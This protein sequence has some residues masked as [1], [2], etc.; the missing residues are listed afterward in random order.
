MVK[1]VVLHVY[2]S[3][4]LSEICCF[5]GIKLSKYYKG[6]NIFTISERLASLKEWVGTSLG[7]Y[8]MRMVPNWV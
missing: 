6:M 5:G 1:E 2:S 7:M 4:R 3:G 8:L